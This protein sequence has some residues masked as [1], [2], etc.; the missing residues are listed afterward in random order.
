[1]DYIDNGCISTANTHLIALAL[2]NERASAVELNIDL[3][4]V[5]RIENQE[6]LLTLHS[7]KKIDLNGWKSLWEFLGESKDMVENCVPTRYRD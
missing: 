6:G 4:Y 2:N 5:Y 7:H 3:N 1:M